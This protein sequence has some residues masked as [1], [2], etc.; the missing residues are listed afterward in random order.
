MF[1]YMFVTC[2]FVWVWMHMCR[3]VPME[4]RGQLTGL[5]LSFTMRSQ[6]TK[7]KSPDALIPKPLHR[8]ENIICKSNIFV[9]SLGIPLS[10]LNNY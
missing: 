10:M 8:P 5:V 7:I 4:I 2:L 1:H 6:V 9:I 3:G